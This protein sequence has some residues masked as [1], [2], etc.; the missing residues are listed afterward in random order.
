VALV[1]LDK[2]LA[3]LEINDTGLVEAGYGRRRDA[4]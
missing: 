4:F 1:R 2:P 3:Y